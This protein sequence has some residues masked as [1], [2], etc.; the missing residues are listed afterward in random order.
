MPIF[1]N[2]KKE[3]KLRHREVKKF[4]QDLTACQWKNQAST[5]GNPAPEHMLLTSALTSTL[6]QCTMLQEG[7]QF[8]MSTRI[9][10]EMDGTNLVLK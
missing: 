2:K 9:D 7:K 10:I 5:P 4:A 6:N 1:K 8:V 3:R